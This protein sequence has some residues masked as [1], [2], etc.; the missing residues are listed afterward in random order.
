LF[1]KKP[2]NLMLK[3]VG[4]KTNSCGEATWED[5]VSKGKEKPEENWQNH[6]I[7]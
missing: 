7:Y 2:T 3:Q 1:E 6:S 4:S 5:L